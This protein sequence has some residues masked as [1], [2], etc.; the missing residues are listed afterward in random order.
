[1][2]KPLS[3]K[4][5]L[6]TG[7]SR[8]LGRAIAKR[9]AQDGALV[10]AHYG[11]NKGEADSLVAE[12][13]KAGGEAFAVQADLSKLTSITSLFTT[14]DSELG[15]RRSSNTIDILVN[16]AG[17]LESADVSQTTEAQFDHLFDI[18]VK[19]VFFV[20][21]HALPRINDGGRIIHISSA[22]ARIYFPGIMAYSI[23]KG[24]IDVLTRHLAAELGVR[25]I[26]VNAVAPGAIETDMN[27]WLQ[28]AEGVQNAHAMQAIKRVGKPDD[29]AGAV[30]MLAG[31][32]SAW[33]TG[34]IVEA[35]GGTKL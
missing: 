1:M 34:Q 28:S 35:S 21:Q 15:K 8:G 11:K 32:D 20:T 19:A 12:I 13:T 29:I 4:V 25:N 24:A 10:A 30:A 23:T 26:T 31:P 22:V 2:S 3:G 14:L 5:A 18:N 9:L 16:N 33:V 7:A 6:V 17:V 27:P